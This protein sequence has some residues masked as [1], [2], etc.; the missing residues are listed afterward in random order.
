MY[1]QAMAGVAKNTY[2]S[3]NFSYNVKLTEGDVVNRIGAGFGAIYG[4]KYVNFDQIDFEEQFVGNGFN[5]N[6]PTGETA[7]SNMKPYISFTGG[8][9]YSRTTERSNIDFGVAAFHVNNPKQTFLKDPNQR[10]AMRKVVHANLELMLNNNLVLN[11]N[12]TY[13]IQSTAY[14]YSFGGS[15]GYYV[16]NMPEVIINAGLWYWSN[17]SL[18]PYF[19]LQKNN[20]QIGLSYDATISKLREA[21]RQANSFELSLIIRGAKPASMA[22]PCPWK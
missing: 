5:T 12:A 16:S 11:T 18:T 20:F 21:P 22:I 15:L 8:M 19:G 14:Y 10:L 3:V 4:R 2:A 17:N 13:Q 6:L 9:L 7:L 1:D